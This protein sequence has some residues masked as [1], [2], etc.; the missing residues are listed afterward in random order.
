MDTGSG[1][2]S[3]TSKQP[4]ITT[5]RWTNGITNEANDYSGNFY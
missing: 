3:C 5:I 1:H 4:A 2:M